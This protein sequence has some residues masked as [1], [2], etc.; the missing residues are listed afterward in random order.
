VQRA[1]DR[2]R[3]P[4][5]LLMV[6]AALFVAWDALLLSLNLLGVDL[7]FVSTVRGRYGGHRNVRNSMLNGPAGVIV[8]TLLLAG[9]AM[10]L[11][12]ASRMRSLSSYRAAWLASL[13]GVLPCWCPC[14]FTP[15]SLWALRVLLD[16]D[17]RRAFADRS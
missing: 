8:L 17:V 15:L 10:L 6:F 7:S 9:H 12:G 13:L 16:P 3:T 2:L 14:V 1:L 11:Y 4:A 5:T